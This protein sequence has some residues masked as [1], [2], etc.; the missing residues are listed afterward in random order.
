MTRSAVRSIDTGTALRI[1]RSLS[2]IRRRSLIAESIGFRPRSDSL[3]KRIYLLV[4]EHSSRALRK[5]GHRSARYSV[6]LGA[7]NYFV[8]SNC[9]NN[10]VGQCNSC[11]APAILA[12]ASCTVLRVEHTK[13]HNLIGRNNGGVWRRAAR[14]TARSTSSDGKNREGGADRLAVHDRNSS[15]FFLLAACGASNPAR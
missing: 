10:R 8:V 7:A 14:R 5:G 4:S 13:I 2:H 12:V 1:A 3:Y 6:R 15:P 11:S 9:E